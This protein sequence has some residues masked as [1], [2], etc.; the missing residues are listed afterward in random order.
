MTDAA[1]Q[2]KID[3][4]NELLKIAEIF[5]PGASRFR[6]ILLLDLQES[7]AVQTKRE[8]NKELLTKQGAQVKRYFDKSTPML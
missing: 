4:C 3:L 6:G 2:R 1:I 7:M 5:E 8:F